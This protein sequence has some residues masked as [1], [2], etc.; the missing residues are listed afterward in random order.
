MKTSEDFKISGTLGFV[1]AIIDFTSAITIFLCA[2]ANNLQPDYV[3][4]NAIIYNSIAFG[5]QFIFGLI[6]D[7]SNRA[8]LTMLLGIALAAAGLI[9]APFTV[10]PAILLVATGNSLFHVGAGSIVLRI[11]P[12]KAVHPG[13]FVAPGAIGLAIGIWFGKQGEWFLLPTVVLLTISFAAA[14]L[15]SAKIDNVNKPIV[16]EKRSFPLVSLIVLL[17]MVSVGIRALGGSMGGSFC[18]KSTYTPLIIALAAFSG[19]FMGGFVADRFG[20]IKSSVIALLFS[21]VVF[22]FLPGTA[23][24]FMGIMLFQMTMPVTLAALYNALPLRSGFAF[25]LACLALVAGTLPT[26]FPETKPVISIEF[27]STAAF[28]AALCI[29]AALLLLSKRSQGDQRKSL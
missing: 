17:L 1:H 23:F 9:S 6:S 3:F 10:L 16:T 25:G 7:L 5:S 21:V 24:A 26:F 11:N 14:F 2:S 15:I 19:K 8:R 12:S 18:L 22:K 28:I 13:V 4:R 29:T 20:W 27:F